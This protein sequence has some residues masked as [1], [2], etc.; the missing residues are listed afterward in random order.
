M[1]HLVEFVCDYYGR[2][3]YFTEDL[4]GQSINLIMFVVYQVIMYAIYYVRLIVVILFILCYDL[5]VWFLKKWIF[6]LVIQI[7]HR[8]SF[9]YIIWSQISLNLNNLMYFFLLSVILLQYSNLFSYLLIFLLMTWTRDFLILSLDLIYAN[10]V[11][12]SSFGTE[13]DKKMCR[14][15][16]NQNV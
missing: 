12:A 15:I 4:L 3:H 13:A 1:L 6:L 10:S 7:M 11:T 2:G 16:S 14:R 9:S 8:I 5:R